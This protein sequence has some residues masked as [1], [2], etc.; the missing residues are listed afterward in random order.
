MPNVVVLKKFTC[1]E[2]FHFDPDPAY[3]TFQFNTD[4][5]PD[6]LKL[7]Y[8]LDLDPPMLHNDPREVP[9]FHFDADPDPDFHF[10]ADP[11]PDPAS[12][13]ILSSIPY[14]TYSLRMSVRERPWTRI[15]PPTSS[16]SSSLI[17]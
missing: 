5:D 9:P 1:K 6:R 17:S 2:A 7:T 4:L 13:I 11:D 14:L 10:D 3:G 12:R 8:F 15:K 16:G